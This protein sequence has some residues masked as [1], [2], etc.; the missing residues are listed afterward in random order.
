MTTKKLVDKKEFTRRE[1]Y[2]ELK[3]AYPDY[4]IKVKGMP[5]RIKGKVMWVHEVTGNEGKLDTHLEI[6]SHRRQN[7]EQVHKKFMRNIRPED[8]VL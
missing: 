5:K 7:D 6:W 3:K 8:C 2:V 4:I 1:V